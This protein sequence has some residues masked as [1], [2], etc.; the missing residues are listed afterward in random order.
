MDSVNIIMMVPIEDIEYPRNGY[1]LLG[2]YNISEITS[3][4]YIKHN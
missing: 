1:I 4:I 3:L 2:I